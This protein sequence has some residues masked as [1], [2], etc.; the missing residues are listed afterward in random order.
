MNSENFPFV[1]E[2]GIECRPIVTFESKYSE[3]HLKFS[4]ISRIS[5]NF[6]SWMTKSEV[7][8]MFF[9]ERV[10][11]QIDNISRLHRNLRFFHC[12]TIVIASTNKFWHW[13]ECGLAR[14]ILFL[15]YLTIKKNLT[16]TDRDLKSSRKL[17][18]NLAGQ[19]R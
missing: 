7:P 10:F 14:L 12:E 15:S 3:F 1:T 18:R 17:V 4:W 8:F 13:F 6:H 5:W 2:S 9:L 19:Y 11:G 16:D